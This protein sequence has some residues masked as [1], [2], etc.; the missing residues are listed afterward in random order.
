MQDENLDDII[1]EAADRHHPAYND[2]AWDQM[3][4]LLDTHLP[5]KK[6]KNKFLVLWLLLLLIGGATGLAVWKFNSNRTAAAI[7]KQNDKKEFSKTIQDS[8]DEKKL[9]ADKTIVNSSDNENADLNSKQ[10]KDNII[11]AVPVEQ[12]KMNQPV[13][14]KVPGNTK[15]V[16]PK[17][18][19]S[20]AF[21]K[22]N[23]R[24]RIKTSN[25]GTH[26]IK[27]TNGS[28]E[29]ADANSDKISPDENKTVFST[30]PVASD[31][32]FVE[33]QNIDTVSKKTNKLTAEDKK[34]KKLLSAA[35]DLTTSKSKSKKEQKKFMSR[36]GISVSA[37]SD[38]TYVNIGNLGK[39]SLL[40]G[41]GLSFDLAKKFRIGTGFYSSAK[42]YNAGPYQYHPSEYQPYL[43][44]LQT[45]DADCRVYEIPLTV[46]YLFAKH[47]KHNFY[48][49][50]GVSTLLM[51]KES[52]DYYYK[53]TAGQ[54]YYKNRTIDNQNKHFF[55]ELGLSVGYQYTPTP[56]LS[57]MAE[58]Y[59]K[60]PLTGVGYGRIKLNSTGILTTVVIRPFAKKK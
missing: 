4:V 34:D 20:V 38:L 14:D 2:K 47:K 37:G 40:Y 59:L 32:T 17:S 51:K 41:A 55:S 23:K 29:I 5:E 21:N 33:K 13:A 56:W 48:T 58:P 44:D 27:T 30:A 19:S 25:S 43:S 39:T 31:P 49:S 15:S 7:A 10:P 42:I 16:S 46:S 53:T 28:V 1:K 52:Y 54:T 6:D 22:D 11:T 24:S 36:F 60:L 35:P 9:I 57:L 18:L 26:N 50:A 3:Q 12:N 8:A 45:I